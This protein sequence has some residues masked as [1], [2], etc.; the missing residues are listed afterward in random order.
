MLEYFGE[1]AGIA[2]TATAFPALMPDYEW[3][4]VDAEWLR[5]SLAGVAGLLCVF[6]VSLGISKLVPRG[7]Q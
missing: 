5:K 6:L 4:K 1:K 7:Q 2:S 3:S